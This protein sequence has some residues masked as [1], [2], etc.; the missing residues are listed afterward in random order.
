[1]FDGS[2]GRRAAR[3]LRESEHFDDLV[4]LERCD[5]GGRKI[6]VEAS[7]LDEALDYIRELDASFG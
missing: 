3:R 6:G 2:L 1:L 4:L 5:R 7:E